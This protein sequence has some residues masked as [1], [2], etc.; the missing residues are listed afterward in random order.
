MDERLKFVARL[1]DD[2]KLERVVPLPRVA[3]RQP[4]SARIHL[5]QQPAAVPI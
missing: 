3:Y 2:G 4:S 1:L 5:A